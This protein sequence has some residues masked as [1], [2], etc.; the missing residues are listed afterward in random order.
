M[1]V[2]SRKRGES[3]VIDGNIEVVVADVRSNRVRLAIRA[4]DSVRILRREVVDHGCT[5]E[6]H[7]FGQESVTVSG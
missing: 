4:P 6:C 3:I 1:L 7:R 2:L 5:P